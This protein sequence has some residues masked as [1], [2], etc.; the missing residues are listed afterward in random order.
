MC[1]LFFPTHFQ[2]L[3]HCTFKL[4]PQGYSLTS[5]P[6][7]TLAIG[8]PSGA[9]DYPTYHPTSLPAFSD[10]S[11]PCC[12]SK[13]LLEADPE[14]GLG[15]LKSNILKGR[16]RK[17]KIQQ[18]KAPNHNADLWS[19]VCISGANFWWKRLDPL[20]QSWLVPTCLYLEV[21]RV[22]VITSITVN[23]EHGFLLWLSSL[24]IFM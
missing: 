24:S 3:N 21:L 18:E 17:S 1:T 2:S 14:N 12:V 8:P 11:W 10:Q 6:G 16:E 20:P 9:R 13:V 19:A 23:A 15:M 7:K 5:P 22:V 4:P